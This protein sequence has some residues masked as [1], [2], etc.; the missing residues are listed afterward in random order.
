MTDDRW[1]DTPYG[2][3]R[4]DDWLRRQLRKW[5]PPPPRVEPVDSRTLLYQ[6]AVAALIDGHVDPTDEKVA[7]KL[8]KTPRTIRRWRHDGLI[9]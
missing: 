1:V 7:E 6:G 8:G 4:K 3:E 5:Q 2:R 9:G